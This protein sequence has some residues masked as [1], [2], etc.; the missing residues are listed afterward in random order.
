MYIKSP[1][2][3][4]LIELLVVIAIISLLSSVV[5]AALKDTRTKAQDIAI[6]QTAKEFQK[7]IEIYRLNNNYLP[8]QSPTVTQGSASY[9]YSKQR[10]SNGTITT[11]TPSPSNFNLDNLILNY[12]KNTPDPLN[13]NG[14][15][16]RYLASGASTFYRCSNNTT[17]PEYVI[18]FSSNKNLNLP[19]YQ[20][21]TL[22][23][24]TW[25]DAG[26]NCLSF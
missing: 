13:F 17:L 26:Y 4:T 3:F 10:N 2:G 23:F 18:V 14:A 19:T 8:H 20:V 21:S 15:T 5:L 9:V 1:K 16:F 11:F 12:Y 6:L 7:A 25:S 22:A 24:P